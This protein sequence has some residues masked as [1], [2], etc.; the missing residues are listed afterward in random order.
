MNR[1][2]LP[3]STALILALTLL[4]GCDA[5]DM[6]DEFDGLPVYQLE[7]FAIFGVDPLDDSPSFLTLAMSVEYSSG[8]GRLALYVSQEPPDRKTLRELDIDEAA[9]LP[10]RDKVGYL[11]RLF[12]LPTGAQDELTLRDVYSVEGVHYG[13]HR[14][15][16]A[17]VSFP[18]HEGD[19]PV[20]VKL[21]ALE[22]GEDVVNGDPPIHLL[23]R[24]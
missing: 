23:E 21:S 13:A 7:R 11:V 14:I 5:Y 24:E 15:Y 6:T 2:S 9:T 20:Q 19:G 8:S 1:V 16:V 12:D 10:I 3:L 17:F 4:V 22:M 18:D